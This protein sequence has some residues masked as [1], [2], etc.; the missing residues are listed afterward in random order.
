[1][2]GPG[3][4]LIDTSINDRYRLIDILGQGATGKVYRAY[5]EHLD[6]EV[7]LK[8][9]SPDDNTSGPWD[10]AQALEKLRSEY[11]LPVY[12]ADI[13]RDL[14]LRF[15]TTQVMTGGDLATQAAGLGVDVEQAATWSR[16]LSQGLERV[17]SEGLLHRDVKP[18]NGYL[19][20]SG[21]ALLGDLGLAVRLNEFGKAPAAGTACTLAPEVWDT[22]GG[23]CSIASDIYSLAATSFF[24]FSGK[25]PVQGTDAREIRDNAIRGQIRKLR[26]IAPH[27]PRGIGTI[28]DRALSADP[29]RRPKTALVFANLLAAAT[30]HPKNWRRIKHEYPHHH[31]LHSD[32]T[33]KHQR[34]D[35]CSIVQDGGKLDIEVCKN[36]RHVR[37]AEQRAVSQSRLIAEL[38]KIVPTL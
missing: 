26:D 31:C 34:I 2:P 6:K 22:T 4:S 13:A 19:A 36:G 33:T 3:E 7:A 9:L 17:H 10:E 23:A 27:I 1:M 16:Q 24:L 8:L 29:E 15:I 35:I 12:N 5:D 11:L 20:S 37:H 28:V 30:R 21:Q 25:Y 14:D 32:R 38:R 18:N